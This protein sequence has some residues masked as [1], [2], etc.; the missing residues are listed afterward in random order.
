MYRTMSQRIEVLHLDIA[1]LASK[2]KSYARYRKEHK[3][4]FVQKRHKQIK[5]LIHLCNK[6]A[7]AHI[8]KN[9]I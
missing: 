1:R 3:T 9:S 8:S 5:H 4:N 7:R 2:L 6:F